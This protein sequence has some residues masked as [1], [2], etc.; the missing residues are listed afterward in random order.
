MTSTTAIMTK[1]RCCGSRRNSDASR[2][3]SFRKGGTTMLLLD[4]SAWTRRLRAPIRDRF[5]AVFDARLFAACVPFMLEVGY[6]ARSGREHALVFRR[7][8]VLPYVSITPPHRA[9]RARGAVRPCS[10]RPSPPVARRRAHRRLRARGRGRRAALRPRLRRAPRAH[11]AAVPQRVARS[12][13]LARLRRGTVEVACRH[14]PARRRAGWARRR[15]PT[16]PPGGRRASRRP[17]P[18]RRR[19]PRQPGRT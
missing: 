10:R 14:V 12:R 17:A 3:R 4:H 5:A 1:R 7:L 6:S 13:G 11:A 9:D 19:R 15:R 16:P 2:C 8:A 18:P